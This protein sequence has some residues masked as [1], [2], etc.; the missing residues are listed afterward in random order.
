MPRSLVVDSYH[1]L[2]KASRYNWVHRRALHT[3]SNNQ[4]GLPASRCKRRIRRRA[5]VASC[6][7]RCAVPTNPSNNLGHF[8]QLWVDRSTGRRM[9][10]G[11]H[12]HGR[13]RRYCISGWL[14]GGERDRRRL[15]P[16]ITHYRVI[17]NQVIDL[18][19]RR[20]RIDTASVFQCSRWP[21][22]P[23]NWLVKSQPHS[24]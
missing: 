3:Q 17:Y 2:P 1:V 13:R 5:L 24:P 19:V 11:I 9:R 12:R 22:R 10:P 6:R 16:P 15:I 7:P 18:L 8:G 4:D 21:N 23:V 14:A 20:R